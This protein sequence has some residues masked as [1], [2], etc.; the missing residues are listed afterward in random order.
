ME[1]ARNLL[2]KAIDTVA[3]TPPPAPAH[4]PWR[5]RGIL[6]SPDSAPDRPPQGQQQNVSQR[7]AIA[8]FW[9]VGGGLILCV[10]LWWLLGRIYGDHRAAFYVDDV[11]CSFVIGFGFVFICAARYVAAIFGALAGSGAQNVATGE[12]VITQANAIIAK[13]IAGITY[14]SPDAAG[15]GPDTLRLGACIFYGLVLLWSA[16][17]LFSK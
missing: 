1:F 11:I 7:L 3:P 17:A 4:Q 8:W 14:L 15:L 6:P 10:G 9:I 16:P 12:G 5:P 2:I 13:L